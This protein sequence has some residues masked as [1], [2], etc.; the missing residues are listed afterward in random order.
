MKKML[1]TLFFLV[2]TI[3]FSHSKKII[4]V[5][6]PYLLDNYI[7]TI[8]YNKTLKLYR[9][10][11]EKT[12]NINFDDRK[13]SENKKIAL[14]AYNEAK[15]NF[16]NEINRDINLAIAFK[17]QTERYD[18]ILEKEALR[19]GK[20]KDVSQDILDFLND[21]Y[22]HNFTIKNSKNL[23]SDLFIL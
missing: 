23:K 20:G 2:S 15:N 3:S 13:E 14:K 18:F 16:I 1:F 21:V 5:D 4:L 17:G 12:Y 19:F 22:Y 8:S 11:L 9:E 6:Y 7:K 10:K